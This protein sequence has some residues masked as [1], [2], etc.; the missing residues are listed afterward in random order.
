MK[1]VTHEITIID[2]YGNCSVD[3]TEF[4]AKIVINNMRPRWSTGHLARDWNYGLLFGFKDLKEPDADIVILNQNDVVF[5]NGYVETLIK[6]HEEYDFIQQGTGDEVMSFTPNA[7]RRI[8]LFDERFCNIGFQEADYFLRALLFHNQKS[9][10]SDYTHHR[11]H[12]N[13]VDDDL[14][15]IENVDCGHDRED[16][17]T[18]ASAKYHKQSAG[19]F[20]HKWNNIRVDRNWHEWPD[21]LDLSR[22]KP[23]Y[24]TIYYPYFEKDVETLV[25][26]NYVHL[27]E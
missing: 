20:N 22:I 16:E 14:V 4:N 3:V 25:E 8:G 5:K 2:N 7:V 10:I 11:Y 6:L 21:T 12:N 18:M 17:S 24:S 1:G 26:Q 13:I 15:I 23:L 19:A 27:F 9:S